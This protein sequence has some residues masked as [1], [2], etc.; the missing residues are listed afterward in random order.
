MSTIRIEINSSPSFTRMPGSFL[1]KKF[2]LKLTDCTNHFKLTVYKSK[3]FSFF[4]G[5]DINQ[6]KEFFKEY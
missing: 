5:I 3:T 2:F 1:D 4:F 6:G